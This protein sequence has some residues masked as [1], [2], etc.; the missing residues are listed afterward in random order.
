MAE[1]PPDWEGSTGIQEIFSDNEG[2][3]QERGGRDAGGF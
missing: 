2:I 1:G 3:I